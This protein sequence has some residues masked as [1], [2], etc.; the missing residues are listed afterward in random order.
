[1]HNVQKVP[2]RNPFKIKEIEFQNHAFFIPINKFL[3]IVNV[4]CKMV[5]LTL[6]R[7]RFLPFLDSK[8]S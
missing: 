6:P 5:A 1:M 2:L 4:I 3:R 8:R 7:H